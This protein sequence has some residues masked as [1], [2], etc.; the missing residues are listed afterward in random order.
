MTSTGRTLLRGATVVTM[1]ETLGD[2]ASAD[3]L[4][5]DGKVSRIGPDLDAPGADVIDVEGCL[6][7]PGLVESHSHLWQGA[8][9]GVAH[10]MATAGEYFANV[11]PLA[12]RFSPE[13]MY[14]ATYS[15]AVELLSLGVTSVFDY[16]HAVNSPEHADASIAAL[17]AA[18]IRAVFGNS[19][20]DRP[21]VATRAFHSLEER[22]TDAA[23]LR[24]A[25]PVGGLVSLGVCLNN[26]EEVDAETN[27]REILA[28][29]ELGVPIAVHSNF[30]GQVDLIDQR[31]LLGPDI[32]W[33]HG[34]TM[35][36]SEL[37]KIAA[38]GG[39]FTFTPEYEMMNGAYPM[40]GRVLAAGITAGIGSDLPSALNAD[41]LFQAR[42]GLQ[43]ERSRINRAERMDGRP[44]KPQND[45]IVTPRTMLRLM[46]ADAAKAIGVGA[47]AGSLSPG[48]QA[49]I[50][51]L[52]ARPF[53]VA[54]GDP[55]AHI[56]LRSHPGQIR[57]VM[58]DGRVRF[59]GGK[60]IGVD[61]PRLQSDLHRI[62]ARITGTASESS[63]RTS[64]TG[65]VREQ[66]Q[67]AKR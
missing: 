64:R 50:V 4:I 17:Q 43:V 41:A 57:L 37:R 36:D 63:T 1:D 29:R 19:F 34:S 7:L 42:F 52:D 11:H 39:T 44:P 49:D 25:L 6:V 28:A 54:P 45:S 32:Q 5:E 23:R 16:C 48:K 10:E 46:T 3:V 14:I 22:I 58:V 56:V 20:R 67:E 2:L 24:A 55:A 9:R 62:Q 66:R 15:M 12:G 18:G 38:S 61:S 35:T 13:D 21:E 26:I 30:P 65:D 33:V 40:T 51:V 31:E 47:Q 27:R 8:L 53:G 60:V 59:A